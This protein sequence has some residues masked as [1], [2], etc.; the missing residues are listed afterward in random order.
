MNYD[1]VYRSQRPRGIR[2]ELFSL[3]RTLGSWV[4]NPLKAW[5]F[6]CVYSVFVLSCVDSGPATG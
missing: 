5:M 2:H 6:V 1:V 3:V 4:Q